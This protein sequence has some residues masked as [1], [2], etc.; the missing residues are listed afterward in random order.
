MAFLF[1]LIW[2]VLSLPFR[3]LK[4]IRFLPSRAYVEVTL[5]GAVSDLPTRQTLMD[6]LRPRPRASLSALFDLTQEVAQDRALTGLVLVVKNP[7]WGL[8]QAESAAAML[9]K[10]KSAGKEVIVHLPFGGDSKSALLAGEATQVFLGPEA[11]YA[12][13]GVRLRRRY[14]GEALRRA[15]LQP[16]VYAKGRYKSAGDMI[17]RESMSD[18]DHE[19]LGRILDA[20]Y[21]SLSKALAKREGVLTVERAAE[22]ID[23]APYHGEKAKEAR[24]VDEIAYDDELQSKLGADG[25]DAAFIPA[26]AYLARH[27]A[28]LMPKLSAARIAIVPLHGAITS[29]M[30]NGRGATDEGLARLLRIAR[31]DPRVAAVVLHIDSPGGSALASDRMHREIVRTVKEKPVVACMGNVAASGGYYAA[32]ACQEIFA[33]PLTLTGSIGVVTARMVVDPL[34]A[35]FGVHADG[36]QRG[37]NAG[38][39]DPFSPLSDEEKV[40]LDREL[41]AVYDGF[42]RVVAKGRKLGEERVRELAEG[43]VWTGADAYDRGLVDHLG[44][45][46]DAIDRARELANSPKAEPVVVHAN[47]LQSMFDP[48]AAAHMALVS[49]L[50][51][52]AG[53]TASVQS[54]LMPLS[55]LREPVLLWSNIEVE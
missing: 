44:G 9:R 23:Q 16:E 20:T 38:L 55:L 3:L 54:T 32:A 53:L 31:K 47:R 28:R 6:L 13:L 36:I 11:L 43:R 40:A 50:G 34:L 5:D 41:D 33:S 51:L 15:G 14:F 24:L 30:P 4:K 1:R 37:A 35:R 12:P 22:V 26:Q 27:R 7:L 46:T 52:P 19:Q 25:K 8:A 29:G 42:V 21:E 18:D 10:L 2:S 17:Q 45:L 39:M 49:S 48:S